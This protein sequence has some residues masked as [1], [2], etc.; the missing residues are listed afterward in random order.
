[1][2]F[3]HNTAKKYNTILTTHIC[4]YKMQES[5]YPTLSN[6]FIHSRKM[7]LHVLPEKSKSHFAVGKQNER[8]QAE[9]NQEA[10]TGFL[11]ERLISDQFRFR[12]SNRK[13]VS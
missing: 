12:Q 4:N 13:L 5:G 11:R 10:D 1:M 8:N 2:E 9:R 3:I 7:E 6:N